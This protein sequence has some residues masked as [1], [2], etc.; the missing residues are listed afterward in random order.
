MRERGTSVLLITHDLGVVAKLCDRVVV[1][2]A[3]QE[4][5][6]A[7]TAAIFARPSHP[8]T[9][10]LLNS[11]PER[12]RGELQGIPGTVPHL[13][14][15]PGGCRFHTRCAVAMAV[16]QEVQPASVTLGDEHTV[17]CHVFTGAETYDYAT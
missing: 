8:Y 7:S 5:E 14:A 16:C 6:V 4:A 11:L 2:Y 17:R 3:G 12:Q 1:M 10:K 15:P 13:I 9:E